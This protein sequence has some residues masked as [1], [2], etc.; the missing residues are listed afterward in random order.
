[1]ALRLFKRKSAGE[2]L[3]EILRFT[4]TQ[5]TASK[6]MSKPKFFVL[7][8]L[9][10][11]V[12]VVCVRILSGYTPASI[13]QSFREYAKRRGLVVTGVVCNSKMQAAIISDEIYRGRRYRQRDLRLPESSKV[14]WNSK[15][16]RRRVFVKEVSCNR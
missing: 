3:S 7:F 12:V 6:K 15:R 8:G 13:K 16:A 10:P 4:V 2:H 1:M 11:S 9:Q 14:V 5:E